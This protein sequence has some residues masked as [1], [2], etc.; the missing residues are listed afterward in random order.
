[1]VRQLLILWRIFYSVSASLRARSGHA[2]LLRRNVEN[3]YWPQHLSLLELKKSH[4]V[5]G[6]VWKVQ[7]SLQRLILHRLNLRYFYKNGVLIRMYFGI[8]LA[9]VLLKVLQNACTRNGII[10]IPSKILYSKICRDILKPVTDS[11]QNF[12]IV[13]FEFK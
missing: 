11:C 9:F 7:I 8:Y 3:K 13:S 4:P 2:L 6:K 1:M 12:K 5:S 10:S